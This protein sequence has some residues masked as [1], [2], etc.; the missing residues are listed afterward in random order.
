MGR[1]TPDEARELLGVYALGALDD[2]ERSEVEDLVLADAEARAE[3]HTLQLGVAWLDHA[4]TGAPMHVWRAIEDE[5]ADEVVSPGAGD[6]AGDDVVELDARRRSRGLRLLAVAA[7]VLA[8]AVVS[9][10][11]ITTREESSGPP[12]V[13]ALATEAAGAVGAR[14]VAVLDADGERAGR[15]VVADGR[16]YLV[17]S[18]RPAVAPSDATYQLW[19]IGAD[20]PRSAGLLGRDARDR[21]FPV[22]SDIAAVAITL[23]PRG[24]SPSPTGIPVATA[25]A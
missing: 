10:A 16:G 12:T 14:S 18:D 2:D 9:V 4:S 6:P 20:G 15:L 8:L 17:W 13:A 23:E 1:L 22:E 11:V 7:A 24:G 3:L 19:T 25:T 5:V 21:A